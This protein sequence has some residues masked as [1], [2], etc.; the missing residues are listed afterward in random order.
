MKLQFGK[1]IVIVGTSGSGKSTLAKQLATHLNY[2]H[3]ELDS[4]HWGPNWAEAPDFLEKVDEATQRPFWVLDGNYTKTSHIFWPRADTIIWLDYP[5][6]VN[7]WRLLRRTIQR[8]FG[9]ELLWNDNRESFREQF[10]SKE[11]LF[12]YIHRTY[13][14]RRERYSKLI[15]NDAYPHLTWIHHH[16][17]RE[18]KHWLKQLSH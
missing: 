10:L 13:Q 8:V 3:I 5:I 6:W 11:S 18:T 15:Q 14:K 16:S 7:Y 2:P 12:V 4:L 1:R 9:K 17:P